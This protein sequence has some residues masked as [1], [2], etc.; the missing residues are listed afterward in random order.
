M[1]LIRSRC[2]GVSEWLIFGV[3][4]RRAYVNCGTSP[5]RPVLRG[6]EAELEQVLRGLN[7][8]AGPHFWLIVAPPKLGKTRLLEQISVTAADGPPGWVTKLVDLY[9]QP[10]EVRDSA[11]ALLA[12]LFDLESPA[13]ADWETLLSIAQGIS[14]SGQPYLCLLD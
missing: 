5:E 12:H 8:T 2:G 3:S 14:R 9:H 6:R 7:Y 1:M 11:G 4:P 13:T 10:A